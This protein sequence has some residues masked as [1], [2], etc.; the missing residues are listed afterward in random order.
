MPSAKW[1]SP[2]QTYTDLDEMLR[3]DIL[4]IVSIGC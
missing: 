1:G 4:Q 3:D 2:I